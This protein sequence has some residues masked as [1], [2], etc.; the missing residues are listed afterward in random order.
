[1]PRS[2]K[3]RLSIM[4][5]LQYAVPGAVIPILS[6]YLK[7][8]LAFGPFRVGLILAMSPV[9]AIVAPFFVTYVADRMISAER[10]LAVSHFLAAAM[11]VI[12]STQTR[13]FGFLG[14]Y[15]AYGLVFMPTFALTNAVAFHHLADAKRDFGPIRMWGPMSWVVVALGFSFLWLRGEAPGGLH[16]R[17]PDALPLSALLS[18]AL[19]LYALS[20][21][22]SKVRSNKSAGLSP[23][24]AFAVFARPSLLLL[25]V[26]TFL[27]AVVHQFY[28]YGMSPFLSQI[29]IGDKYIMPAM[30]MGQFGEVF[31]LALLGICLA[32][33]GVKRALI[34]GAVAQAVRCLAFA[35]GHR[36][37]VLGAIPSH[38]VCY[39]FFFVVAYIY[40]D[41]HSSPEN[42]AGAQQLFNILIAGIGYLVGNLF[43][44]KVAQLL[45]PAGT[46]QIDFALFWIVSAAMALLVAAGL[47]LFFHEVEPQVESRPAGW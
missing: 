15:F 41:S 44:G 14:V 43:A 8:H 45:T 17:L 28:Y 26:L 12:L 3:T 24:K 33:L 30:S 1:V 42:R 25:C 19:G 23:W 32:K 38:G 22:R 46:T 5:F 21:P 27:N 34:I 6:H 31:V 13:F 16:N 10:L 20:L 9:A 4:M 35:T 47:A 18:C 37:L 11:M 2:L 39:A 7:N 36:V 40:V 29:G